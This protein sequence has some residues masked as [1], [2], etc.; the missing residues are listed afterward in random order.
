MST[1]KSTTITGEGQIESMSIPTGFVQQFMDPSEWHHSRYVR[2]FH[3]TD[4]P[5]VRL[6][7]YFRGNPLSADEG[8]NLSRLLE[9]PTH[10]LSHEEIESLELL[11]YEECSPEDFKLVSARTETIEGRPVLRF[12]GTWIEADLYDVGIFIQANPKTHLV[13]EIH[14]LAPVK[15]YGSFKNYFEEALQTI[16]WR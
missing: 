8:G 1:A 11:L 16:V 12:E 7:F 14:F 5:N 6:V 2:N 15:D 9:N 4:N 3:R 10:N 13:Q